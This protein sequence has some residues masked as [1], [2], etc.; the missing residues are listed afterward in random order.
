MSETTEHTEA[1]F[2]AQ[3]RNGIDW[4]KVYAVYA[5]DRSE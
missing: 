3:P 1:L 4:A 2:L 5:A